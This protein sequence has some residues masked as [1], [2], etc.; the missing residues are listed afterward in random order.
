MKVKFVEYTL[1]E[2]QDVN[3]GPC[4]KCVKNEDNDVEMCCK[5]NKCVGGY[6]VKVPKPRPSKYERLLKALLADEEIFEKAEF[7][8]TDTL[9]ES[10]YRIKKEM[11]K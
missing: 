10:M 3:M 4:D 11:N 5:R 9:R 1:A 6:Y 8:L 7:R 2:K